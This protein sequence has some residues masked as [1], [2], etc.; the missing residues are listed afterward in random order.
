[1]RNLPTFPMCLLLITMA[2]SGFWSCQSVPATSENISSAGDLIFVGTASGNPENGIEAIRLLRDGSFQ[3]I[4]RTDSILNP[5]FLDIT[6][7]KRYLIAIHREEGIPEGRIS[8][9]KINPEEG[10]LKYISTQSTQGNGPCYV[11]VEPTGKWAMAANYSSGSAV[12]FAIEKS[13]TLRKASDRVVHSGSSVNERRQKGPH[14]HYIRSGTNGLVYI[15][16]LG[17]DK[18]MVYRILH[19]TGEFVPFTTPFIPV[20]P[21]AG[22]R[23]IDY[24]PTLPVI[25]IMNEL[26][27][28]VDVVNFNS[29][30]S[31]VSIQTISTLPSDF[32]GSNKSADI[33]VHPSG[34][35][36]Y[37]SNRGDHNSVAAF[38]ID[39][40]SGKLALIEIETESIV[41]PRNFS[42]HPNGDFLLVANKDDN[43]ITS[44]TINA[45]SGAL[46]YTG[47]KVD[48]PTPMCIR[49]L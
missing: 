39:P 27:G 36:L 25:Y 12:I 26:N 49:F 34:N 14:A 16:D 22:P 5:S 15:A 19:E 9:F 20:D 2:G 1:M 40:G 8:S 30:N 41:W 47:H 48:V 38:T 45:E 11:S 18:V 13:G 46:S 23:H 17:I 43:S 32:K 4:A 7:D 31:F 21:G 33:H 37:A 29:D 3:K 42:I 10:T 44:F 28:T 24:H 6:P 35:Y